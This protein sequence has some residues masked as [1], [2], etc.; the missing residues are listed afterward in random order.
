MELLNIKGDDNKLLMKCYI[1]TLF[2]AGIQNRYI[3]ILIILEEEKSKTFIPNVLFSLL[4]W[5]CCCYCCTP[6]QF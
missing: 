2:I 1:V 5:L 3:G 4:L 6:F